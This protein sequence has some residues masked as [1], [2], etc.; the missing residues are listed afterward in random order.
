MDTIRPVFNED[1]AA[2]PTVPPTVPGGGDPGGGD[3][4][5]QH[6]PGSFL[7]SVPQFFVFPLILVAT[8]TVIYLGL[9]WLSGSTPSDARQLLVDLRLSGP[10]SRWQ[11]AQQLAD[12]LQ[13][14]RLTLDTVPPAELAA[15]TG[16]GP[17]AR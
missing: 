16:A 8:L 17:R 9:R 15:V 1:S 7:Q 14:G 12:G 5:P 3:P 4:D 11:V 13:R 6:V 2:P 10:H